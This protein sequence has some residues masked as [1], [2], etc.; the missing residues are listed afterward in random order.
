MKNKVGDL[1][2][3]TYGE[4][5]KYFQYLG[6]DSTQLN[7]N[8]IRAFV[9]KFSIGQIVSLQE[10]E[11]SGVDFFAH[12]MLKLGEKIGCWT[13]R[14]NAAAPSFNEIVFRDTNDYGNPEIKISND[15]WVWT[16]NKPSKHIGRLTSQF[17]DSHIGIVI[18]PDQIVKRMES[19]R[20][21]F[22]YP[23]ADSLAG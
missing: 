3:V 14:G 2:S 16:A 8:V 10:L 5:E 18:S 12:V 22:V 13:R 6:D 20:F 15:W 9:G 21:Q 4:S 11:N 1:F 23:V 7:S 17:I 19:G